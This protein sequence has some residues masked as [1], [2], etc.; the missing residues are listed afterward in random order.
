MVIIYSLSGMLLIYR[1]SDLLKHNTSFEKILS[2]NLTSSELSKAIQLRDLR[3]LKT[4]G[5]TLFFKTGT[6]NKKTGLAKYSKQTILFPFNKFI[7]LHTTSNKLPAHLFTTI[8]GGILLFLAISSFWMFKKGSRLFR[9]G[10]YLSGI[11]II[12]SL[13]LLFIK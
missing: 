1:D 8:F 2:T 11:G 3:V 13:L 4:E 5:D 6:Y 12:G 9:R 10:L 7:E